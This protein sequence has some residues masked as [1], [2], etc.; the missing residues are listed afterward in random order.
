MWLLIVHGTYNCMPCRL[1]KFAN[2]IDNICKLS[3]EM[4]FIFSAQLYFNGESV[5]RKTGAPS[6]TCLES[7]SQVQ[8]VVS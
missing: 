3:L 7:S 1:H 4:Q 8:L 6:A 5:H 2:G